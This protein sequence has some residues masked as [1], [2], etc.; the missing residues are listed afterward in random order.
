ML[1]VTGNLFTTVNNINEE[2]AKCLA[3]ALETNTNLKILH[4]E[5]LI[6]YDII[7][8]VHFNTHSKPHSTDNNIGDDGV[9]A[10]SM[11]LQKNHTVTEFYI[12][13]EHSFSMPFLMTP[14]DMG[15]Q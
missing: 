11:A 8:Y 13:S 15:F 9:K 3:Q 1:D 10:L 12:W 4:L 6:S 7:N 14:F 5:G 2:G